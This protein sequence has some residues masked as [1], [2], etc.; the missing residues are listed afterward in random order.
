MIVFIHLLWSF[1]LTPPSTDSLIIFLP[2]L[3]CFLSLSLSVYFSLSLFSSLPLSSSLPSDNSPIPI[4]ES[5][6]Y[7]GVGPALEQE[8]YTSGH[9]SKE[10]RFSLPQQLS[11]VSRLS[12]IGGTYRIY[13]I[14][15]GILCRHYAGK[16][17]FCGFISATASPCLRAFHSIH[18][19]PFFDS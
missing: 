9:T 14:H 12:V 19:S 15:A 4:S 10:E 1:S 16:H 17:I 8:R 11:T 18:S 7:V 3:I 13:L 6:I 2:Y 5:C